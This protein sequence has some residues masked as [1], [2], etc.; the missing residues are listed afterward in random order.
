MRIPRLIVAAPHSG[1]GKTTVATGL[2]A[3]LGGRMRVGAAKVGPDFVDPSY[4]S[5]ATGRPSRNL[6]AW[7]CGPDAIA[8]LAVKAAAQTDVLIV[9]GVMGL[10]DG[11][12][13]DGHS[14][15]TAHVATLLEAPVI[16]VVDASAMSGSVAAVVHGFATL[17][18]NV[19]V[20]G[21]I[22]NRVGSDG[23]EVMLREA[24]APLGIPVLGAL[25][26]DD[27]FVWRDR[28]LGLVPVV[29]Q[30]QEIA[31]SLDRLAAAVTGACDLD[32]LIAIA[33]RAPPLD[34]HPLLQPQHQAHVRVAVAQGRAFSF[35]YPDNLEALEA[36]G[37]ELLPF[38]PARDEHLPDGA[39]GLVAGGGFPEVYAEELAANR[40]LLEDVKQKCDGGL[41]TWA[42][43][44]GLLWLARSLDRHQMAGVIDAKATMTT[45]LTLGYRTARATI[46]S[47]IARANTELRGHEF[48]Y[49]NI[50]PP[51]D[52]LTLT[53]RFG[54]GHAGFATPTLLASY[55]HLHLAGRPDIAEQFVATVAAAARRG[56]PV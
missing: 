2:M 37:A 38:D 25:R 45:K 10:F 8:P 15:S 22:L 35:A 12:A 55:L 19:D 48:H 56:K 47:P 4:H 21:V 23:H 16:L 26:R 1:A 20:A 5:L 7:I 31:A 6:D 40:P 46:D 17:D 54:T 43:C 14:A 3:A 36:A 50:E 18:K 51:G 33:N 29:E 13:D 42:E 34:A 32:A 39:Q 9:E 44:G 30:P 28:H 27:T 41:V 52:G 49:S 53:A 11:A 24:L